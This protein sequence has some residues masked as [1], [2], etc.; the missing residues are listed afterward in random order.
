MGK[1]L[2]S[3]SFSVKNVQGFQYTSSKIIDIA[4]FVLTRVYRE[5]ISNETSEWISGLYLSFC[6]LNR[7]EK[8]FVDSVKNSHFLIKG[9]RKFFKKFSALEHIPLYPVA[10]GL[11][12]IRGLCIFISP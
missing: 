1:N 5:T 2:P 6:F 8:S 4:L 11:R 3:E 9:P 10:I 12:G 7:S